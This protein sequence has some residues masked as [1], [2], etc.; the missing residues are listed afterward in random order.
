MAV[1]VLISNKDALTYRN[2]VPRHIL[3]QSQPI[4]ERWQK[5]RCSLVTSHWTTKA[6]NWCSHTGEHHLDPQRQE[7]SEASLLLEQ[8][9]QSSPATS[10]PYHAL[11]GSHQV[12]PEW[13]HHSLVRELYCMQTQDSLVSSWK[14]HQGPI[15]LIGSQF[16][17]LFFG[18]II[19]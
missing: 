2:E 9:K 3:V 13:L 7:N 15:Q 4:S 18:L 17:V 16:F 5:P 8:I 14:D 19:F 12:H 10:H 6:P 1:V 11:Q